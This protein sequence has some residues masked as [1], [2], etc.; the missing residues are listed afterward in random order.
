MAAYPKQRTSLNHYDK[1]GE[2]KCYALSQLTRNNS[3]ECIQQP[4]PR[5][6]SSENWKGKL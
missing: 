3:E 4:S 5:R 1:L 2:F 6:K